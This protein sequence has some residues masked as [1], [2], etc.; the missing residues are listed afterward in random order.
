M[1]L[2]ERHQNLRLRLR[3]HFALVQRRVDASGDEARVLLRAM[4]SLFASVEDCR[5]FALCWP[6]DGG[7][8]GLVPLTLVP[9]HTT[10][11]Y[12][13][14]DFLEVLEGLCSPP[15][16]ASHC[17][18][19]CKIHILPSALDADF[20]YGVPQGA[21]HFPSQRVSTET[22]KLTFVLEAPLVALR[23][24]TGGGTIHLGA[25][26]DDT[27]H[28]HFVVTNCVLRLCDQAQFRGLW[29]YIPGQ[30]EPLIMDY[31]MLCRGTQRDLDLRSL[32]GRN[33]VC[34][35]VSHSAITLLFPGECH[36]ELV[37][38]SP[39]E[40][41][42]DMACASLE[43]WVVVAGSPTKP[44]QPYR[45]TLVD[46]ELLEVICQW[47][48]DGSPSRHTPLPPHYRSPT[49]GFA[50]DAGRLNLLKTMKVHFTDEPVPRF[51][52]D[53]ELQGVTRDG[54]LVYQNHTL[55]TFVCD[56]RT[57]ELRLRLVFE[58]D[59][60]RVNRWQLHIY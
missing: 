8:L 33:Q 36:S 15:P 31:D 29:I 3:S 23:E 21:R 12:V 17:H 53:G 6:C 50:T 26:A 16:P 40:C 27:Q 30:Q 51:F 9:D 45:Y 28:H 37:L 19:D 14:Y 47:D 38:K 20:S 56:R 59:S 34:H 25:L 24:I 18:G 57:G 32:A 46:S 41:H 4:K 54:T 5:S 42:F 22:H 58:E 2:S 1:A 11:Q 7:P 35:V 55:A 39:V 60:V 13:Y 43:Y 49:R 10:D 52:I 44:L 48:S